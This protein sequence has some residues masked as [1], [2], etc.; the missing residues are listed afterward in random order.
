M[1]V[2]CALPFLC[3]RAQALP[4]SL[5]EAVSLGSP[6]S[7]L[8]QGV[9]KPQLRVQW[10]SPPCL[11]A[12]LSSGRAAPSAGHRAGAGP[13]PSPGR[14]VDALP[15]SH[16]PAGSRPPPS[17]LE[18]ASCSSAL[19]DLSCLRR[20]IRPWS[21]AFQ[22]FVILSQMPL[23]PASISATL[24]RPVLLLTSPSPQ[25][26]HTSCSPLSI[27]VIFMPSAP[28]EMPRLLD[29]LTSSDK[30]G[31]LCS[32]NLLF[33]IHCGLPSVMLSCWPVTRAA[34]FA[35]PTTR[36]VGHCTVRAQG[37]RAEAFSKG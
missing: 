12:P 16:P 37:V 10:H 18:P 4:V 36:T 11:P 31:P 23:C 17:A 5:W 1:R 29:A 22:T 19:G 34:I 24:T 21:M 28:E 2:L 9:P 32:L 20:M 35:L 7:P 27:Q 3:L 6:R 14:S 26:L 33:P 25:A 15:T 30:T 8:Q 13:C